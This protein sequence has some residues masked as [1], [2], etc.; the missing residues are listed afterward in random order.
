MADKLP[1]LQFYTGDWRK[2]PGVQALDY[3]ERGVWFEILCIMH[4]SDSRGKLMLNGKKMPDVALARLLGLDNQTV[5][6]ILTK[7]VE[8]GVARAEPDTGII[9]NKRMVEDEKIRQIRREAGKLGGNPALLNQKPKQKETTR[10]KQNSTP[11]SSSSS[12]VSKD[13]GERK[14]RATPTPTAFEI[15][16]ELSEW[17]KA[18]GVDQ[19]ILVGETDKFLDHWRAKGGSFKDWNAAWRKWMRNARDWAK[20]AQP[21]QPAKKLK[22]F[23]R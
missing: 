1:A 23:P 6:Q 12:S 19:S 16:P 4:E 17:A 3:F 13:I 8:Y 20:S 15:T 22:E 11:S 10:D 9:Y 7:L 14:N 2:D 21:Q 18:N 5:N